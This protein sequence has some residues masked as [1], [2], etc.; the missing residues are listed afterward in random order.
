M[1]KFYLTIT[2]FLISQFLVGQS[3]YLIFKNKKGGIETT[4]NEGMVIKVYTNRKTFYKGKFKIL[5][6]SLINSTMIKIDNTTIPIEAVK[7]I[8]CYDSSDKFILALGGVFSTLG[9]I[10]GLVSLSTYYNN[11]G[12]FDVIYLIP[13]AISGVILVSGMVLL[14]TTTNKYQNILEVKKAKGG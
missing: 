8:T 11:R 1:K 10:G 6:D 13:A 5:Y 14:G 2:F 9:S 4:V 12:I 3:N 7:H